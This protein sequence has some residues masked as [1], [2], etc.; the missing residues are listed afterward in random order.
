[1]SPDCPPEAA[2]SPGG[3][4]LS[5]SPSDARP[6]IRRLPDLLRDGRFALSFFELPNLALAL[7]FFFGF[8]RFVVRVFE[9]AFFDL[10][11]FVGMAFFLYEDSTLPLGR[12]VQQPFPGTAQNSAAR[13]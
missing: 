6:P 9:L 10:V 4:K 7:A 13:L 5:N 2:P 1:M 11:F 8:A 3:C 12:P